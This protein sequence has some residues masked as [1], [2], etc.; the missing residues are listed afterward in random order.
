MEYYSFKEL[1]KHIC[2]IKT[3]VLQLSLKDLRE[4]KEIFYNQ[5]VP[6]WT[7]NI[8]WEYIWGDKDYETM[9]IIF[10]NAKLVKEEYYEI[11]R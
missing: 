7:L 5:K 8:M 4:Y 10:K 3:F 6:Y 9:K 11:K 2:E 1:F